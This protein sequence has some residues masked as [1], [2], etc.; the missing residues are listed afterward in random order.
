MRRSPAA[1]CAVY[2]AV[3]GAVRL[4]YQI[5]RQPSAVSTYGIRVLLCVRGRSHTARGDTV[6]RCRGE[7]SKM[8]KPDAGWLL[9]AVSSS[10]N[11]DCGW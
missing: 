9:A 3:A 5:R 10:V 11:E 6:V 2:L 7:A 1:R 8:K 4:G